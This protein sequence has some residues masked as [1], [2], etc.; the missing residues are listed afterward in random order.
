MNYRIVVNMVYY[1]LSLNVGNLSGDIYVNFA[2]NSFF[3]FAAYGM[4]L[5]LLN[6]VGRKWL[7]SGSMILGGAAC[8]ST[9]FTVLYANESKNVHLK[10]V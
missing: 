9:I 7:H 8:L 3:E 2:I 5:L 10:N 4:C 6:R 1:G